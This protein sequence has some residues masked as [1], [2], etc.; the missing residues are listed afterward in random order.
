M[1][2][3]PLL[4]LL[5]TAV[6]C[7]PKE[8]ID[9]IAEQNR[10]YKERKVTWKARLNDGVTWDNLEKMKNRLGAHKDMKNHP[11]FN[12]FN[13]TNPGADLKRRMQTA[14]TYPT[15]FDVRTKYSKCWSPSFIRNQ[16]G[17]GTCWAVAG[18]SAISDSHC[19]QNYNLVNG[20]GFSQKMMSEEDVIEVCPPEFC[21]VGS[22]TCNGGG[23][24][25][26]PFL[27]SFKYGIST[28][29]NYGNNTFCKPYLIAP[30][31]TPTIS[32]FTNSSKCNQYYTAKTYYADKYKIVSY[33]YFYGQTPQTMETN[34]IAAL[35]LYG[36]IIVYIDV[37]ECFFYYGGGVYQRKRSIYYGGHA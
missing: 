15:T 26:G 22:N 5:T 18:A 21:G 1:R 4:L 9:F 34:F 36:P 3:L 12:H 13:G 33:T 19:I 37:F 10:K 32:T 24:L 6:V 23:Y 25:D 30:T 31:G 20:T 16:G 2:S 7:G 11:K 28:G 14:T 29:A 17:C 35:N 27:H 8:I